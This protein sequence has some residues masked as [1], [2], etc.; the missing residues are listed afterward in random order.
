MKASAILVL[1]AF[2][3]ACS[4]DQAAQTYNPL[5]KISTTLR[6]TK[7]DPNALGAPKEKY[8]LVECG[9]LRAYTPLTSPLEMVWS[10]HTFRN[11]LIV[12][13]SDTLQFG[14]IVNGLYLRLSMTNYDE[15]TG[16][17][18]IDFEYVEAHPENAARITQ[19]DVPFRVGEPLMLNS[20]SPGEP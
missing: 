19:K 18:T 16:D 6:I 9:L 2:I 14:E 5:P 13:S 10:R 20:T 11:A 17:G 3:A 8:F 4:H 15:N 7:V 1:L 12:D